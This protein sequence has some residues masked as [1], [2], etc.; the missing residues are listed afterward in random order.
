MQIACTSTCHLLSCLQLTENR[1]S[2]LKRR[3]GVRL[4]KQALIMCNNGILSLT[5]FYRHVVIYLPQL[6]AVSFFFFFFTTHSYLSLSISYCTLHLQEN[7]DKRCSS[8]LPPVRR[9]RQNGMLTQC[10]AHTVTDTQRGLTVR[11]TCAPYLG[12][13]RSPAPSA[14]ELEKHCYQM[15]IIHKCVRRV[16]ENFL[17]KYFLHFRERFLVL[18]CLFVLFCFVFFAER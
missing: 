1:N 18:F 4:T 7:I 5:P 14:D 12:Y 3:S 2:A 15:N 6:P 8:F 17:K 13:N 11:S 16:S 10:R 9:Y